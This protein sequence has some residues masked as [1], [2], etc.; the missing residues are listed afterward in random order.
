MTLAL[1]Y[2]DADKRN[3]DKLTDREKKMMVEE[4]PSLLTYLAFMFFPAQA[5]SGPFVEFA[6][7]N[8]YINL[9]GHYAKLGTFES[10]PSAFKRFVEGIGCIA[11]TLLIPIYIGQPEYTI[12]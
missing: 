12:S 4:V 7:F 11:V 10:W 8:Q 9:E 2:K 3:R 1:N 5:I 6:L